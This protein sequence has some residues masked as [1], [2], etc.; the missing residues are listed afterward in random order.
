MDELPTQT[1]KPEQEQKPVSVVRTLS[2][3]ER[4]SSLW[5]SKRAWLV[6]GILI[7]LLGLGTLVPVG[8]IPLLRQLVYAMGYTQDEASHLSLLQ[9]LFSWSDSSKARGGW[10]GLDDG[11]VF[12]K[13]GG[14]LASQSEQAQNKLFDLRAVNASLTKQGRRR[15]LVVDSANLPESEN[16]RASNIRVRDADASANTQA[17]K[18]QN[19][20]VFF[21]TE[22]GQIER[23]K[24]DGFNSVN[25]LKKI[26]NPYITGSASSG[27]WMDRL[28]DKAIRTDS[29]LENITQGIERSGSSLAN[30]GNISAVGNSRARR[31]MYYA[32]LTGRAARRTPQIVLKKTLASAGFNGAEMPRT[33]FTATGFS[34]VGINPDDVIADLDSVQKYLELDKKCQEA[35]SSHQIPPVADFQ[36]YP[37]ALQQAFPNNCYEIS[38]GNYNMI[39]ADVRQ[40]C[41]AMADIYQNIQSECATVALNAQDKCQADEKLTTYKNEFIAYCHEQEASC[42]SQAEQYPDD[43]DAYANCMR[44]RTSEGYSTAGN[45]GI[46]WRK[47]ALSADAHNTFFNE[48]GGFN[49]DY[50]PGVDW[51]NSWWLDENVGN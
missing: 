43:P 47:S 42:H 27:D 35:I 33:V 15:D 7:F 12:G 11:V 40:R 16:A 1:Q 31:D 46:V 4:M 26:K 23:D 28:V 37:A 44:G 50:F 9:A 48:Q 32:W 51:N 45:P 21:G 17:N 5:F 49:T 22:V 10:P 13:D 38:F 3:R 39:L 18:T 20:V 34:G 14:F 6:L 19:G 30:L 41:Q 24:N 2:F 29:Q 25:S 8:K 36:G